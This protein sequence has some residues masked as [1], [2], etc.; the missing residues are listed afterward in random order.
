MSPDECPRAGQ[1]RETLTAGPT[2][3]PVMSDLLDVLPAAGRAALRSSPP[4]DWAPPT[5][6]TLTARRFSDPEWLF[7]RKFD[8]ERCLG[9]RRGGEVRLLSRNR[10]RLDG[11]YPEGAEGLGRERE[12]ELVVDGGI[13]A[14][15]RG[16]ARFTRRWR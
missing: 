13:V 2:D 10:K 3:A 9:Y 7:E 1:G 4:P 11:T 8:G 16:R 6:A 12:A 15:K 14:V 5:L